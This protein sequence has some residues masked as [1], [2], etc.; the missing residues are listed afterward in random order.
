P[1]TSAP[2]ARAATSRLR[3]ASTLPR[4]FSAT[5][6]MRA[7]LTH[8]IPRAKS[9]MISRVSTS[10]SS[11]AGQRVRLG[12][13][14]PLIARRELARL[15]PLG[16][17]QVPEVL[18]P[19]IQHEGAQQIEHHAALVEAHVG[20]RHALPLVREVQYRPVQSGAIVV[21]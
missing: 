3:S 15:R 16:R 11:L 7:E 20:A 21:N 17:L 19:K 12:L 6:K 1:V 14:A 9:P 8:K 4:C 13:G 18:T 10:S 5:A 2:P